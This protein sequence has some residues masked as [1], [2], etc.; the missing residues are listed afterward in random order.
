MPL[1]LTKAA[2]FLPQAITST[3]TWHQLIY[4]I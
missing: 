1:I 3:S 2:W 4:Q